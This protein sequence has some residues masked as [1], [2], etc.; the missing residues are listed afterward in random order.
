MAALRYSKK[1]TFRLPC[2]VKW[3]G[4]LCLALLPATFSFSAARFDA[5]QQPLGALAPLTLSNTNLATGNVKAYR[6]WFENG[7]WQGDLIEYEVSTTGALST[8]IDLSGLSPAES[9]ADP[10]TW[11]AH[12]QIKEAI[13]SDAAYW[14]TELLP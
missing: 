4:F 7:S 1:G 6:T 10:D 12:V 3:S 14:N 2:H 11:S 5:G 13:A 9:G 8:G